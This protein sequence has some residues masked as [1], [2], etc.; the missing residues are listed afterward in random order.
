[1]IF[2]ASRNIL[3]I[4]LFCLSCSVLFEQRHLLVVVLAWIFPC[5]M[6]AILYFKARMMPQGFSAPVV[7]SQHLLLRPGLVL[8]LP[9]I[10][11]NSI[12]NLQTSKSFYDKVSYDKFYCIRQLAC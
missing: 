3:V 7:A 1:M 4:F 8:L 5:P 9:V 11:D 2:I 6:S 10:E 12:A